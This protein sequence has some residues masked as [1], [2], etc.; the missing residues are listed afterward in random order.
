MMI[1]AYALV[2]LGIVLAVGALFYKQSDIGLAG[3]VIIAAGALGIFAYGEKPHA[4]KPAEAIQAPSFATVVGWREAKGQEIRDEATGL[5]EVDFYLCLSGVREVGSLRKAVGVS[6]GRLNAIWRQY[7]E[8]GREYYVM[9]REDNS[10]MNSHQNFYL[11][12]E[13]LEDFDRVVWRLSQEE[14]K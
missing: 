1:F 10:P 3:C 11:R 13:R 8:N 6:D 7:G 12:G 14:K 5:C 4:G 9:V 2:V